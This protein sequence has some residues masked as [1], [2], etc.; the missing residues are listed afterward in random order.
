MNA[1]R[2]IRDDRAAEATIAIADATGALVK[3]L[4]QQAEATGRKARED[5]KFNIAI[6]VGAVAGAVL[7]AVL[8]VVTLLQIE[9]V[10]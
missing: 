4:E 9:A 10:I 2:A 5:R 3:L 6:T 8:L 7:T 1:E